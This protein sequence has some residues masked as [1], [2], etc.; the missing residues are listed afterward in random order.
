MEWRESLRANLLLWPLTP[1]LTALSRCA[2]KPWSEEGF[3]DAIKA[4]ATASGTA[5]ADA[6]G[7]AD[8]DVSDDVPDLKTANT[9]RSVRQTL[10]V[11]VLGGLAYRDGSSV[12]HL[13]PIG[14]HLLSFLRRRENGESVATNSNIHLAG[15]IL[16]PGLFAVAEYRAIIQ[17]TAASDG[18]LSREELNRALKTM[19]DWSY[20]DRHLIETLATLIK[21][22]R[23]LNDPTKIGPR[24]YRDAD[25]GTAKE[26]DQRKAVIPWFRLAG[27]GGLVMEANSLGDRRIHP[28]LIADVQHLGRT[29]DVSL[30]LPTKNIIE[31]S[32]SFAMAFSNMC[33]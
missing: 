7:S 29:T 18:H 5:G 25:F 33:I 3:L 26:S 19:S 14:S 12:I 22:S 20:P 11:M 1:N 9:A 31:S 28:L 32:E 17:L 8:E 24:W 6:E 27:G 16:L 13:T 23:N 2:G 30:V 15:R 10:E 21:T 4:E